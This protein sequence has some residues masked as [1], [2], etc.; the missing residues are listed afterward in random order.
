VEQAEVLA[1]VQEALRVLLALLARIL[2]YLHLNSV[3]QGV[4]VGVI[5]VLLAVQVV[6]LEVLVVLLMVVVEVQE[7]T[8]LV[9]VQEQV[10]V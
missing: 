1:E 5:Q 3:V 10:G 7:V 2:I 9:G 6:H 8:G 4:E